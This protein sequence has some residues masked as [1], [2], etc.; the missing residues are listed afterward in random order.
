MQDKKNTT[1]KNP[2]LEPAT[3]LYILKF[4]KNYSQ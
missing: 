4:F 3:E 2:I 1:A